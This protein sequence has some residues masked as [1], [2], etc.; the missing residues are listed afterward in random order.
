MLNEAAMIA[1]AID[2]SWMAGADEVI[3]CDGGSSDGSPSIAGGQRCRVIHSPAGRGLQQN[4]AAAVAE[5]DVLLFLHA[6]N[7][8]ASGACQQI[9]DALADASLQYGAFRQRIESP[10]VLYRLIEYGNAARV[11]YLGLAYGDQGIFVRRE[12]FAAVGGFPEVSLMEDL[13]LMRLLHRFGPPALL[14]GP[15]HV[16]PRR[17]QKHGV[18]RQ[19]LCNWWLLTAEKFGVSPDRLARFYPPPGR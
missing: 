12:T 11:R 1:S 4:Q 16:S 9:R 17:W 13:R 2:R 8:L 19:T 5:G 14:P 6:D 15:L 10:R 3:V 7:W 18:I